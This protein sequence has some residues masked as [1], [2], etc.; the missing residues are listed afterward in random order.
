MEHANISFTVGLNFFLD[1]KSMQ[2]VLLRNSNFEPVTWH[3]SLAVLNESYYSTVI[4]L[5]PETPPTTNYQL[6]S[7]EHKLMTNW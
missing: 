3:H 7:T 2:K 5:K 6:P 4:P 1:R